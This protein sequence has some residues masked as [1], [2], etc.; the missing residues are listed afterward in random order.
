MQIKRRVAVLNIDGRKVPG[1]WKEIVEDA[2]LVHATPKG[3][4][5]RISTGAVMHR[6][7]KDILL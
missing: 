4:F 2:V 1:Q 7:A 5:V 3:A 6:K